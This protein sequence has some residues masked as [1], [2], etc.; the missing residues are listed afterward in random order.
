MTRQPTQI[1]KAYVGD[2]VFGCLLR[3][4]MA[5][6]FAPLVLCLPIYIRCQARFD[7]WSC[8]HTRA[9]KEV[10]QV[11]SGHSVESTP[12]FYED[13]PTGRWRFKARVR[14][15]DGASYS[16]V[17]FS[18]IRTSRRGLAVSVS[19]PVI[20]IYFF[21][22]ETNGK[23]AFQLVHLFLHRPT[24]DGKQCKRQKRQEGCKRRLA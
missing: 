9:V 16:A 21:P 7:R 22:H 11:Y 12:V 4:D 6:A 2:R 8:H 19:K 13:R 23:S 14:T 20:I 5:A 3:P 1:A 18:L 10:A 15:P 17:Y 24:F